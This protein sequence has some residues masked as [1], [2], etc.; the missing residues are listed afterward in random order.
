MEE[1]TEHRPPLDEGRTIVE[2]PVS[3]VT[4][5]E[6]RALIVRSGVVTAKKGRMQ[7]AIQG[8]SPVLQDVSLRAEVTSGSA[9]VADARVRRAL[10][11][12]R[13]DRPE[14]VSR[15]ERELEALLEQR[16]AALAA[17][18][19][20]SLRAERLWQMLAQSASELP[21]DVAWGRVD[22][23]LWRRSFDALF[24]RVRE[25]HGALLDA[26]FEAEDK[27]MDCWPLLY[28]LSLLDSPDV[29]VLAVAEI[30]LSCEADGPVALQIA[31]TAPNAMWR[32]THRAELLD[33]KLRFSLRAAIWQNTGEAWSDASLRL[34]TARTSL[35]TEPPLLGD[36][37]L[38]VKRKSE[39]VR[40]SAR[41]VEIQTTGPGAEAPG[42]APS[43][44]ELPGVDDGGEIRVLQVPRRV[45]VPSDGR[46][47]F[48]DITSFESKA[49]VER[50]SVPE[51]LQRVLIRCEA[52]NTSAMPILAGPV[53][54]LKDYGAIGAT[55]IAFVAPG[56]AFEL[57][58]GPDDAVRLSREAELH[59]E[60][61][62]KVDRWHRRDFRV[63]LFL[64]NLGLTETS[65]K[66][67]ERV[68]VSEVEEVKIRLLDG[69]TSGAEPDRD[70]MVRFVVALPPG[71][72]T[73]IAL[74]YQV[75]TAPGVKM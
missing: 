25:Q 12:R 33:G 61:V 13:S 34:S 65:V 14:A 55:E 5:L 44:L 11:I 40:L 71:G 1:T 70:G 72:G 49:T 38:Q 53:E 35:A 3:E 63:D 66:V 23:A 24:E 48:F 26:H 51:R 21:E 43:G 57:S 60:E 9:R 50:I 39:E 47:A 7:I 16:A 4:V 68:P 19:R 74:R 8:V 46:P 56:A 31:Y 30:D 28:Q 54:L 18:E 17:G 73:K 22:E 37:L 15:L 36:D 67:I 32:P 2:L 41:E 69:T 10:R 59:R 62:D 29:S 52:T 42:G 20:A 64:S 45:T 27:T 58:F 6:D 75:A